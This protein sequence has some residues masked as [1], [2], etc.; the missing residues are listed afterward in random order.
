M[1]KFLEFLESE[2]AC[3]LALKALQIYI[4][5]FAIDVIGVTNNFIFEHIVPYLLFAGHSCPLLI[6]L[7]EHSLHHISL[8]RIGLVDPDY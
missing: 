2:H 3:S 5:P 4:E 7:L 6:D 1:Q 8:G